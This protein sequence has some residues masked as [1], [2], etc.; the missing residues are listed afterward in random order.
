MYGG[1]RHYYK[2]DCED[3]IMVIYGNN[4]SN[5]R[6]GVLIAIFLGWCGG[7]RFYKKQF[8]LGFIYLFTCG[9]FCIG[10]IV[11]IVASLS[12]K[13][14]D[15]PAKTVENATP[16]NE[17]AR[18]HTSV[19]GVTYPT[20]QGGYFKR[21]EVLADMRR[22]DKLVIVLFEYEGKPAYRVVNDRCGSDIGNLNAELAA[23]ISRKYADC[24]IKVTEWEVTGG[25]D[26]MKYGCNIELAFYKN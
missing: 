17:V 8:V 1:R 16:T 7:Y 6:K 19:V 9:L 18:F 5:D 20:V 24:A 13:K 12:P 22:K 14:P 15:K 3:F 26:G 2:V 10:W 4:A 25:F 21:Q 11:D 23:E